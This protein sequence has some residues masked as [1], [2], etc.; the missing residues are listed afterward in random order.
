MLF[1]FS[2]NQVIQVTPVIHEIHVV[3][4]THVID[5]IDV[6]DV[7]QVMHVMQVMQVMQAIQDFGFCNILFG[8]EHK[9][10]GIDTI[11][12]MLRIGSMAKK[13]WTGNRYCLLEVLS[14]ICINYS[15]ISKQISHKWGK[16][17]NRVASR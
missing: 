6:I 4:I 9:Y 3:H 17:T 14:R 5:V 7:I 2:V 12:W 1:R 8:H 11:I 16:N 10:D 13:D 15:I